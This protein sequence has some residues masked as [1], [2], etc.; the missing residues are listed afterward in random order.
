M[1]VSAR[2]TETS[3][4]DKRSKFYKKL[5]RWP[6]LILSLILFYYGI[7]GIFMNHRRFFSGIDISREFLPQGYA[8]R[9]WNNSALKGN[10]IINPD[11]ILVFG[12]IGIWITDSAFRDYVSLNAGFPD[13]TDHRKVFDVHRASDGELYAATLFGLYAYDRE[14]QKWQ[15]FARDAGTERFVGIESIGDTVYAINRSFLLRGKSEG[16][17]TRFSK[18]E[19]AAPEGYEQQVSLFET[20]WQTHSG[21]IIGL[22]GK[23]FVDF[24]GVITVFLSLTGIIYFFF[25]GWIKARIRKKKSIRPIKHINRWSLKWHNKTGAWFYIPLTILFL[26]GMFLRPPL[27]IAIA[28]ANIRPLRYSHL[29]QPNP[30]YD[31]LRDIL[32]DP[33]KDYFLL[34][35]SEGMYFMEP[36]TGRPV[37]FI[38]QP[39]VSVMGINTFEPLQDGFF[40]IGSFSGLFLWNPASPEVIDYMKGTVWQ[41]VSTGRPVGDFKVTGVVTDTRGSRYMIDYGK[42]AVPVW[43]EGIFPEMPENVLRESRMSLWSVSLEIHTG[44]I[45]E[46]VLGIFYILLVP[47]VGLGGIMVVI[48]GYLLWR[49][50]YRK[51]KQAAKT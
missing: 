47:L 30:W 1:P 10:L 11:S 26:T 46:G 28:N 51:K 32:Y 6:G 2:S 35:T 39:P 18:I 42:G 44:R 13:G 7:T 34:S 22:P 48:S 3:S 31:K 23:L 8:Y 21:E 9:N 43:H 29:D 41:G 16:T 40:L 50:R 20:L 38:I 12:N 27:L 49:K 4:V 24:L 17:K 36:H 5:H 33:E 14:H 37:R 25:P 45:F 15:R 19:L